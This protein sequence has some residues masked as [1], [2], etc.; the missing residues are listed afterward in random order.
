[1]RLICSALTLTLLLL[2]CRVAIASQAPSETAAPGDS[3]QAP[4]EAAATAE[5]T[6]PEKIAAAK[7]Y[8]GTVNVKSLFEGT[9]QA[10]KERLP[11]EEAKDIV[12]NMAKEIKYD[13]VERIIR[14]TIV[15]YFT[16]E[17]LNALADFYGSDIGRSVTKK[18][19]DYF[20]EVNTAVQLEAQRAFRVVIEDYLETHQP[21]TP[22][23][24]QA[25]ETP[26]EQEKKQ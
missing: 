9:F 4:A 24:P 17:E 7:R 21:E 10:I 11:E 22:Q 19:P 20:S 26:V 25:P 6:T 8:L 2:T 13:E 16:T 14:E 18:F 15:N 12:D 5:P 1:M 3:A 23:A